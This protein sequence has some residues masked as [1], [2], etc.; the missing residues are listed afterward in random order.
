MHH[1]T[2]HLKVEEAWVGDVGRVHPRHSLKVEGVL[3]R[4]N[5][6]CHL[7]VGLHSQ[8]YQGDVVGEDGV[9]CLLFQGV[10]QRQHYW[11]CPEICI[12]HKQVRRGQ[13]HEIFKARPLSNLKYGFIGHKFFLLQEF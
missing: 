3:R 10:H 7:E 11:E 5:G 6:E 2:C 13:L 9:A 12:K 4:L 8:E 1:L